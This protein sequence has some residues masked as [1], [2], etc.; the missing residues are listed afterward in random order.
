MS[1]QPGFVD[2]I[3]AMIAERR[4][5]L[6]ELESAILKVQRMFS[7]PVAAAIYVTPAEPP[8]VVPPAK[9]L[10]GRVARTPKRTPARASAASVRTRPMVERSDETSDLEAAVLAFLSRQTTPTTFAVTVAGVRANKAAVRK[11][12][13]G[14]V[15][16]GRVVRRGV[17]RGQ[18]L[19][20]PAVMAAETSEGD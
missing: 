4:D 1:T 17:R 20:L 5:A 18:R 9:Q 13:E 10:V 2:G 11:V 6:T 15:S 19:G 14:L 16:D 12:L 3:L 8:A 7:A